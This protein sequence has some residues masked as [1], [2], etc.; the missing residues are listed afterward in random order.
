MGSSFIKQ[1]EYEELAPAVVAYIK[2]L[3]EKVLQYE[4]E[5]LKPV[6]GQLKSH[7][8]KGRKGEV[9]TTSLFLDHPEAMVFLN[10]N[11]EV[12]LCNSTFANL[13]KETVENLEG[14]P[15]PSIFSAEFQD[16]LNLCIEKAVSGNPDKPVIFH[17]VSDSGTITLL[18]EFFPQ[19]E[20]GE[21]TGVYGLV[22]DVTQ[23]R[24]MQ[25]RLDQLLLNAYDIICTLDLSGSLLSHNPAF[26]QT[27]GYS[28]EELLASPDIMMQMIHPDDKENAF[29]K[30]A[31]LINTKAACSCEIRYY[32]RTG[33][34]RYIQWSLTPIL[35]DGIIYAIGR[36][37][38]KSKKDSD[39]QKLIVES[40]LEYFYVLDKD[41]NVT[42]INE[43]AER[44]LQLQSGEL[45][46]KNLLEAFP[47]KQKGEFK[48][49]LDFARATGEV[50][51]FEYFSESIGEWFEKSFYPTTDGISVFFRSISQR[52]IS[53]KELKDQK[54]FFEQMFLQSGL[55]SQLLD[56]DG[57][58]LRINHTFSEYFEVLPEKMEV[59]Q[60]N[61]FEDPEMKVRHIDT[62]LRKV[63]SQKKM[64]QWESV[65]HVDV[66][67][68][69]QGN[70]IKGD[71]VLSLESTAYPI[72][73]ADGEVSHFIIQYQ[74]ITDRMA[75]EN[76]IL[77]SEAKYRNLFDN[78][79]LGLMEVDIDEKIVKAYPKFC[80][81]VGYSESEL[82]GKKATEILMPKFEN[83]MQDRIE[84]RKKGET[85]NYEFS[86]QRKDGQIL[87]VI[88]VGTPIFNLNGQVTGS[89]GLHYDIT[90]RKKA[91]RDLIKQKEQAETILSNIPIMIGFYDKDGKYEYVNSFWQKE[92][93]WTLEEMS[94]TND[95]LNQ[96]YPDPEQRQKV[97]DF[98]HS[99]NSS[100]MDSDTISRSKGLINTS[101]I[102]VPLSDGRKIAIG[103][104]ITERKNAETEIR[105]SNER[106]KYVTQATFDAIWDSDLLNKTTYWGEGFFTLFGYSPEVILDSGRTFVDYLHPEDKDRVH[107][108]FKDAI[109]GAELNWIE[110]YQFRKVNGE[111]AFVQDKAII[112]RN[113]KGVAI[114]VIG[115]MHDITK[116]KI[117]EQRLKL[118]ESVIT[119]SSDSILIAEIKK[120]DPLHPGV[121][122]VNQTFEQMS[123]YTID[124]IRGKTAILFKGEKSDE[125]DFALLNEAFRT[126]KPVEF[127]ALNYRKGG[128]EYWVYTNMIPVVNQK[129][130]YSHWISIQRDTTRNK[131]REIERDQL[132][133]DL[134][135]TNQEL[136]QFSFITSHNM[137]AP[138]TNLMA[139]L[140]LLDVSKIEDPM[141]L[142]LL[143]GFR[144][145]TDHLNTTLNDLVEILIIKEKDSVD[146]V[147]VSFEETCRNVQESIKSQIVDSGAMIHTNFAVASGTRF[148][149]AYMESIFLNLITNS[150][151]FS[152]KDSK[153]IIFIYSVELENYTQL[154]FEDNGLGFNMAKVQN[155]IFGLYQK[156]HNHPDSKGIGLYLVHSQITSLG[157]FIEVESEENE[158]TKFIISFPHS[159]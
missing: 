135:R 88:I 26:C 63:V 129:G 89:M 155:K 76:A 55:A 139:I 41:F 11:G 157:G 154:I 49:Y 15:F 66:I 3:E 69:Y 32:T 8:P 113:N 40:I 140:E 74:D 9:N 116:Q 70:P 7:I 130:E 28:E 101:W 107:L 152:K 99:E 128:E 102:N 84:A 95:F 109:A 42:Y 13:V 123:G 114:R 133:K 24:K 141:T 85:D 119:N 127:E 21:I 118:L 45:I 81:M 158:G 75:V 48:R 112:I 22:R 98:I 97:I 25:T 77:Q 159:K 29:D 80:E 33:D 72:L 138:L 46:G 34:I 10:C 156:F 131:K 6:S 132:V 61:I 18:A 122:Y 54:L 65:F 115:A 19:K 38:T 124:E 92:L 68:N 16:Q 82:L 117:E 2:S 79:E 1:N 51:R 30:I 53:E 106:F 12:V 94:S 149:P 78:I 47:E 35:S 111:Y 150:I 120:E 52:K 93:G 126:Y 4:K 67:S 153:P 145:S 108:S 44:L 37:F 100:W 147:W 5:S 87:D 144:I 23:T 90:A 143:D 73:D 27:F 64:V 125:I 86:I 151:K 104:N 59:R 142:K 20:N 31:H 58:C 91:E 103:Q 148:N 50:V 134:T 137:R 71:K 62:I 36:D 96:L 136:K 39:F 43:S 121:V 56:K 57:W 110:E 17:S 83:R 14:K 146:Q 60:Y 105:I